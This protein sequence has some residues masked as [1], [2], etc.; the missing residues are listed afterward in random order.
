MRPVSIETGYL[1]TAEGSALI[2]VGNTRVL[3]AATVDESVPQFMR[4][5]GKGWVTAE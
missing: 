2:S 3:C 1:K 4:G 5:T